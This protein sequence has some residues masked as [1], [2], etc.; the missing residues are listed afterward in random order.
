MNSYK[1]IKIENFTFWSK[2]SF[3]LGEPGGTHEK[4]YGTYGGGGWVS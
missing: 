1:T 3:F 2:F 4:I